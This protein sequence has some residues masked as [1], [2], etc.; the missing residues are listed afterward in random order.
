MA[1]RA[2]FRTAQRCAV[3]LYLSTLWV[4]WL[5][6]E[7]PCCLTAPMII[8]S[9]AV[10]PWEASDHMALAGCGV[11]VWLLQLSSTASQCRWCD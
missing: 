2:Q 9:R 1:T 4:C 10:M 8:P 5:V 6:D 11:L 7:C 3:V